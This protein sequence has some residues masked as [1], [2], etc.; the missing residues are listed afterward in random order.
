MRDGDQ[1][2]PTR[3]GGFISE[4]VHRPGRL[5][6]QMLDGPAPGSTVDVSGA[7]VTVGRSSLADVRVHDR[8]ISSVHFELQ[9][10]A[11][12][13]VLRDL[14]SKNGVWFHDRKV[15]AVHLRAGDSFR[16]GDC[17]FVL[18]DVGSVEVEALTT[19]RFGELDG[20]SLTMRE[21]YKQIDGLAA[22]PLDLLLWGETGTGK[23][24]TARTIHA[25]SGRRGPLVVLDCGALS[26]TLAEGTIFGFRKGAFTGADRNQPGVFEAADGGTLFIDEVGELALE[27]QV[28]LLRALDNREVTRLGEP[29]VQRKVDVRVVAATHRDLRKAVGDGSFR[30]DLY[31]RIARAVLRTPAL[32][33][34]GDDVIDLAQTF[35]GRTCLDFGLEVF[36]G[37]DAMR[38]LRAHSWPGNVRELRNAIEEAAH[39]KR[40]GEITAADL[41]IGDDR[42]PRANK[43][44]DMIA[45]TASY[46]EIHAE[47]DKLLLPR[48]LEAHDHNLTQVSKR[49]G[50]SRDKLRARLK[51]L[52]LY[53]R[54]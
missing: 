44:E 46:Q 16:A 53:S 35:V 11:T 22:T 40:R 12:G 51:E 45:S 19:N 4:K 31:Y 23:D 5:V 28:K 39:V 13:A 20:S 27:L 38:A 29:G 42:A 9:P 8:S 49:V 24:L 7:V 48:V 33:D 18:T 1:T 52:G 6:L 54:D 30:E 26:P 3:R 15:Q 25:L 21:L 50:M 2:T 34:R 43:I 37:D 47:V 14:R 32:R 17:S 36:L 10:I 41:R